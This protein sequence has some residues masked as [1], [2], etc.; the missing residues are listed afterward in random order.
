[1][2]TTLYNKYPRKQAKLD[3]IKAIEKAIVTVAKRDFDGNEKAAADWLGTRLDQYAQSAQGSRPEK[4]LIPLP[5]TWFNGGR[6]DD[7]PEEWRYVGAGNGFSG[8]Q[9]PIVNQRPPDERLNQ[10]VASYRARHQEQ[11]GV[12]P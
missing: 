3:G 5:A 4:S 6:Y 9:P 1:M 7:D 2:A 11:E 10:Q 8:Q 12:R